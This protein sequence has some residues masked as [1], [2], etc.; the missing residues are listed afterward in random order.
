[1]ETQLAAGRH[2]RFQASG[3]LV[4]LGIV[5]RLTEILRAQKEKKCYVCVCVR[6]ETYD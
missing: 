3:P 2:G 1:M 4:R 5:G 6:I